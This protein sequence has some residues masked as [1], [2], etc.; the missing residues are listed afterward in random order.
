LRLTPPQ[1]L[2]GEGPPRELSIRDAIIQVIEH[3]SLHV[4]HMD[5]VRSLALG[6][7]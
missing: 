2:W 1:E 7:R 4:G 3:A 5:V 6:Q